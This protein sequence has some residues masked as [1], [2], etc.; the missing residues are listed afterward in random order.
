VPSEPGTQ[1]TEHEQTFPHS[2]FFPL[3]SPR[4]S[5]P[6]SPLTPFPVARSLLHHG[7]QSFQ[8]TYSAPNAISPTLVEATI[9]LIN[10]ET[11]AYDF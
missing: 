9:H 3:P 4:A 2:A 8:Q 5:S 7:P 6:I 10:E 1:K 11:I